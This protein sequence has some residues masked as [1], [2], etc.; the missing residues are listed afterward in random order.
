MDGFASSRMIQGDSLDLIRRSPHRFDLIV[1]DPPYAFGGDGPEH[2]LSATVAIVLRES[3]K[4][5]N[6]GCW[7]LVFCASSWRSIAYTVESVRGVVQPIRIGSWHKP[8]ARTKVN[9]PGWQWASVLVVAFRKGKGSVMPTSILDHIEAEPL[10]KGRRAELP[11]KVCD[12]A[13]APFAIP[14]RMFLDPFAGSGALVE[15]AH[16]VGMQAVGFER[17]IATGLEGVR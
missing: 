1:T 5:L 13:V 4:R 8:R 16:R 6:R 12:W 14:G 9:T 15:A 11:Q 17:M 7:M 3:A 10:M 2:A